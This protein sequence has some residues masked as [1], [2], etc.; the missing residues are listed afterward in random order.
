[1][2][3]LSTLGDSLS[4]H[5]NRGFSTKDS[6]NDASKTN[7]AEQRKGAWWYYCCEQ[8]SLNGQYLSGPT[9]GHTGVFWLGWRGRT[10]SLKDTEMKLRPYGV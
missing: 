10:Y 6:D 3:F 8:S 7:C 9:A 2:Y 5:K 1:M 4:Y